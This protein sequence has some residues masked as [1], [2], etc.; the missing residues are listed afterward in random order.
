MLKLLLCLPNF[1]RIA[2]VPASLQEEGRRRHSVS[3]GA[4][5]KLAWGRHHGRARL[6][7]GAFQ[8]T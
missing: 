2:I 7:P 3:E 6:H 1:G 8:R 4:P 5:V